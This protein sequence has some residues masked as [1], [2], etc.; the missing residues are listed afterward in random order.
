MLPE[1]E[2]LLVLQDRDQK[3][4]KMRTELKVSPAERVSLN[5]KLEAGIAAA[6]AVKQQARELEVDKKKLELEAQ[7]K[8]D[9]ITR[10]K[11]QQFQTRKN[12]EFQ[13]LVNEIKRYEGDIEKLEDRELE[14]MEQL[15]VMKGKVQA[16]ERDTEELKASI[17]RQLEALDAKGIALKKQLEE[18][19]ANRNELAQ[20]VDEDL[21]ERYDRLFNSKGD[22]AIVPLEHE[23]CMGCHMKLTTQTAVRV[24]AQRE[25]LGCEQCGRILYRGDI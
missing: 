8:R 19:E 24:R 22:L 18:L 10:F 25:I 14:V 23:V 20:G 9:S 15:E 2:Q 16:V 1:I 3:I 12:E 5:E 7:A 4:R 13:A 11:T 21:L 6:E 17:K